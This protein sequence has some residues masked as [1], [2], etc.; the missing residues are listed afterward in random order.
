MG[1]SVVNIVK[2]NDQNTLVIKK[3]KSSNFFMTTES[4]VIIS[5]SNLSF[6]LKYMLF[7]G[8]ISPKLLEGLLGEY[9][10]FRNE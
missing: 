10:D 4:S 1:S 2:L 7:T 9:Y 6:L 3:S 5:I 8:I